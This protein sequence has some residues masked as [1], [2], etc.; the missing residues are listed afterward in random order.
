[1]Y[2][3]NVSIMKVTNSKSLNVI[4]VRNSDVIF[5]LLAIQQLVLT[6]GIELPVLLVQFSSTANTTIKQGN[7]RE[8]SFLNQSNTKM[9][10]K[11]SSQQQERQLVFK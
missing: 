7:C 2:L 8:M 9:A 6:L 11:L 1:M 10:Q 5:S 4:R 3:E